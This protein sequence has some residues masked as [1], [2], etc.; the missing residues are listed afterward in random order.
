MD[1]ELKYCNWLE[2]VGLATNPVTQRRDLF[3]ARQKNDLIYNLF[4]RLLI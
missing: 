2:V 3:E 1:V 4:R